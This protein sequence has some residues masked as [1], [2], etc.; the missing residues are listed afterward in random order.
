VGKLGLAGTSLIAAIPGGILAYLLVMMLMG[1][2][3]G[4]PMM[5]T[6]LAVTMLVICATLVLFP[7]YVLIWFR[8]P[9]SVVM[10]GSHGKPAATE[11]P[12][13]EDLVGGDFAGEEPDG[14]TEEWADSEEVG[15]I[16]EG[17]QLSAARE[18]AEESEAME[19]LEM[20]EDLSEVPEEE[21][22][23][24]LE[25]ETLEFE[26]EPFETLEDEPAEE[27]LEEFSMLESEEAEEEFL[28]AGDLDDEFT[29]DDFNLEDEEEDKK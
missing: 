27:T 5:M 29:F 18:A 8:S 28:P 22:F 14:M 16:T 17:L 12:L 25:E 26:D 1:Q 24:E 19:D 9:G 7:A 10:K 21:V 3:Q 11:E 13:V 20:T 2:P 15:G 6:I 23:E 4:L